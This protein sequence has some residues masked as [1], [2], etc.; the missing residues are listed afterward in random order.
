M[1]HDR[2]PE[3]RAEP[4]GNAER[5]TPNTMG[6]QIVGALIGGGAVWILATGARQLGWAAGDP[7]R[8]MMWGAVVGGLFGG[9]ETLIAA[10]RRLTRRDNAWLNIAVALLGMVVLSAVIYGLAYLAALIFRQVM[11]G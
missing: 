1:D 2:K 7:V 3:E 9:S 11:G 8:L 4:Q 5:S 10:G 6:R